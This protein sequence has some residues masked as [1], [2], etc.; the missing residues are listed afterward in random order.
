MF[1]EFERS[2]HELIEN[3]QPITSESLNEIYLTLL[4]RYHGHDSGV[5]NIEGKYQTEWAFIPHFHRNYYVYSYA[6]SFIAAAA[7]HE[8]ILTGRNGGVERYV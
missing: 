6:T 2:M 7:F 8:Q 3:Q 4:R 1:A 5:C